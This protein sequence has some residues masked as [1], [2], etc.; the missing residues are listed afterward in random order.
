MTDF[1]ARER[2]R[3]NTTTGG[4]QVNAV[5]S[6]LPGGGHVVAWTS[7]TGAA[8]VVWAQEYDAS[9]AKSGGEL[10]LATAYSAGGIAALADGTLVVNLTQSTS[11]SS[12][13]HSS[14]SFE[15]FDMAGH[16]LGAPVLLD[17]GG[18]YDVW[19][20]A[21]EA[22]ALPGGGFAL[23]ETTTTRPVPWSTVSH[24]IRYFDASRTAVASAAA[25]E[26]W[27]EQI[28][29]MANGGFVSAGQ[30][31]TGPGPSKIQWQ[32]VDAT[33]NVTASATVQGIYGQTE[34]GVPSVVALA[35]GTALVVWQLATYAN[36]TWQSSWQGQWIDAG[37][38]ASGNP[39][40][41]QFH[42]FGAMQLTALADGGFLATSAAGSRAGA[43]YDL[44]GQQF[45]ATANPVG[46]IQ[47]LAT[48]D[49]SGYTVTATPDGGFLVDYQAAADGQDIFEQ[50]F[51]AVPASSGGG[52]PADSHALAGTAGIDTVS[53][54]GAHTQY[55]VTPTS[56]SGPEGS[57]SLSSIER[58][59]F[60]DGFGIALDVNG[61]AGQ[62]YRLYQA[63]FD[64]QPDLPGLGY[65]MNDLDLGYSLAQVA[66]NFIASPEF[67]SKYGGAQDDAAFITLLYQHV[68]HRDP[69]AQGLQDHLDELAHGYS[70][71]DELTFF[72]ESP[73]NQAN[74]IGQIG[75]GMLFVPVG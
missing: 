69:E 49:N 30:P 31:Y 37:G 2:E 25:G 23:A 24:S 63:A 58:V 43:P 51:D 59:R 46:A 4:D 75:N 15:R 12:G 68:L 62:A 66:A 6:A 55:S 73:E 22:F 44:Y 65:Q 35:N 47:H 11:D 74:V 36:G 17:G 71:A 64:R 48:L 42:D 57:F 13:P 40:T 8:S 29:E 67:Q 39:F 70:R 27:R 26:Y 72:S 21:G 56:I 19:L 28:G 61:H 3:V 7:G 41:W 18:N 45:D 53:F 1:S 52:L 38:H 5:A 50:K 34:P 54:A 16:A 33:G 9:G 20:S 10:R 60:S 14:V 32:V